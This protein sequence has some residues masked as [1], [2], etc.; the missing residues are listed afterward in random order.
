MRNK[1]RLTAGPQ[2]GIVEYGHHIP[3]RQNKS[4]HRCDVG[5]V[6]AVPH[7]HAQTLCIGTTHPPCKYSC[8]VGARDYFCRLLEKELA[9]V[10]QLD[11]SFCPGQQFRLQLCLKPPDLMT[12]YLYNFDSDPLNEVGD[13]SSTTTTVQVGYEF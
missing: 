2:N 3:R 7:A 8:T 10:C 9:C 11:A 6:R 13:K 1:T 12:H 4:D 5:L